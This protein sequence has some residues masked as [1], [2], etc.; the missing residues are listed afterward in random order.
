M[1]LVTTRCLMCL[2]CEVSQVPVPTRDRMWW[3]SCLECLAWVESLALPR[4]QLRALFEAEVVV[5]NVEL[6]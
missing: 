2:V 3:W 6:A 1:L 5:G 4:R